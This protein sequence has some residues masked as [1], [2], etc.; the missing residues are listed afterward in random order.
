MQLDLLKTFFS[1]N[2]FEL[3]IQRFTDIDFR[4]V[5]YLGRYVLYQSSEDRD[6]H[7]KSYIEDIILALQY[8]GAILIP[9]FYSLRAHHNKVFMELLRDLSSCHEVKDIVSKA[10]GTY[11]DYIA[12]LPDHGHDIVLKPASGALSKGVKLASTDAK[13]RTYAKSISSSFYPLDWLKNLVNSQIRKNYVQKSNHRRKFIVQNFIQGLKGDYKIL[14]YFDKY[15]VLSREIRKNDFRASGSGI[16]SFPKVLPHGLLDYA[17]L[18]FDSFDV[19]FLSLD[20]A[21]H[22]EKFSL[23]EFQMLSFGTYTLEKSDYFFCLNESGWHLTY[24]V[25]VLEREVARSVTKHINRRKATRRV[26]STVFDSTGI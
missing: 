22:Q 21:S 7:Y 9:D 23:I 8:Q 16:F 14:V 11:E 13:K 20:V 26:G 6:L 3:V 4:K 18:V 10:Y 15:Y 19:P 12:G 1:E 5:N 25:P 17:K 2:G 24:E